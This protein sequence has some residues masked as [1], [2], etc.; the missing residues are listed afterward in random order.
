MEASALTQRALRPDCE[1]RATKARWR[2]DGD[3]TP[4]DTSDV[5]AGGAWARRTDVEGESCVTYR[6]SP[7]VALAAAAAATPAAKARRR[8]REGAT[9][10]FGALSCDRP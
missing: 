10:S 1:S 2:P 6:S 5:P 7:T 9:R 4:S 8:H 3:T